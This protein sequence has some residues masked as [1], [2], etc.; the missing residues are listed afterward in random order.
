MALIENIQRQDLNSIEEAEGYRKLMDEFSYTQEE[1]ARV[2][3][4]SR[5]VSMDD[6]DKLPFL[7][8]VILEV[9]RCRKKTVA[10]PHS[11]LAP[12]KIQFQRAVCFFCP[13]TMARRVLLLEYIII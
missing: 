12:S 10:V 9:Q 7:N 4:K 5:M 13:S 1:L 3:G 8:A 2:V 11:N 6:K